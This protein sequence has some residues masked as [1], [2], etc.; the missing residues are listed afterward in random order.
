MTLRRQTRLH[1]AASRGHLKA[2]RALLDAGARVNVLNESRSTPLHMATMVA[3]SP[4]AVK[5]LL[6]A[7]ANPN[8]INEEGRTPLHY[9]TDPVS[10]EAL[11]KA[12]ADVNKRDNRFGETP[13]H[14][15][16]QRG[17]LAVVKAL[18]SAKANPQARNDRGE[19]PLHSAAWCEGF[20][21]RNASDI[22]KI[23]IKEGAD[24][25]ARD[26]TGS[27]PLNKGAQINASPSFMKTL[28]EA[29]ADPKAKNKLGDTVLHSTVTNW[30][31]VEGLAVLK[32]LIKEEVDVN[33]PD[34]NGE[35]PL[36]LVMRRFYQDGSLPVRELL[37]AGADP[38]AR[39]NNGK[40]LLILGIKNGDES[41][42]QLLV[43]RG[44][45]VNA[46]D[47]E[48][49]TPLL[50]VTMIKGGIRE[51]VVNILLNAKADVNVRDPVKG[52]TPLH[53]AVLNSDGGDLAQRLIDARADVHAGDKNDMTPLH[54]AAF[55]NNVD[56]MKVLLDA[57]AD[58]ATK[59][60]EGMTAWDIILEDPRFEKKMD[61]AL[62]RLNPETEEAVAEAGVSP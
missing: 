8:L 20:G 51:N 53:L 60:D 5:M 12:G 6:G 46:P 26:K 23:L 44:A 11:I 29:D 22:V 38:N 15:A 27:T 40:T 19:T 48:G 13:L 34:R 61:D 25:D 1:K 7:D 57:G 24:V 28:L 58:P 14:L 18:L 39:D 37:E 17:D 62:R 4:K 42:V 33:E 10:V 55:C 59:D 45:D 47:R 36:F 21:A 2:M 3:A 50:E 9:A 32:M 31:W 41:S 16:T 52:R 54:Y 35:S 49:Y 56:A 43:E 30:D